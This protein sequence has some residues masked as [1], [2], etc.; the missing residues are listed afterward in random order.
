M[1]R[2]RTFMFEQRLPRADRAGR[3]RA[4]RARAARAVR[5]VLRASRRSCPRRRTGLARRAR[6]R[7][8]RGDD[9]PL[10][11]SARGP[12]ASCRRACRLMPRYTQDSRERVRDAVDFDELVGAR[13]ELRQ[14]GHAAAPGPVPV[15]RR[16][17][18]VV[19]HRPRREALPLLRLRGGRRRLLV[20]DGDRGARLRAARW[21][22]WPTAT[23]SSSSARP[24]IRA[25]PRGASG[26]T[27]CCALLERTAAYYVR[28]LWE[29]PE[30]ERRARVPG[31]ARAGGGRAARVPRRLLAERLGPRADG[32]A[33]AG[34]TG[35]GAAGAAGSPRSAR[36]ARR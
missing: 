28:V 3:A 21:S 30:A 10:R 19:R 24:R 1:L 5:L 35:R 12:S 14:A 8:A 36:R 34:Y 31:R 27:A 26:A 2:L 11:A 17:D 15:P 32:V 6:H 16:A 4:H 25:T 29:S 20:R 13:T 33:R 23:G 22:R 9:R 7:L 18:A